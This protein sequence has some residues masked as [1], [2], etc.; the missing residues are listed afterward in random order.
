MEK[1]I[2]ICTDRTKKNTGISLLLILIKE[3]N[4]QLRQNKKISIFGGENSQIR[5]LEVI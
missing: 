2:I 4:N 1:E 5:R 3:F